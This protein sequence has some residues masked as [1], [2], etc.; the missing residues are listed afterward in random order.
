MARSR[1]LAAHADTATQSE[2]AAAPPIEI[3]LSH[4]YAGSAIIAAL[5]YPTN[6]R[7]REEM[8][9]TSAA[10]LLQRAQDGRIAAEVHGLL[11]EAVVD[12]A[13]EL[14]MTPGEVCANA[15]VQQQLEVI[16]KRL[17]VTQEHAAF[18]TAE[19]FGDLGG[20]DTVA[21]ARGRRA[22]EDQVQKALDGDPRDAG[23]V[24]LTWLK[25]ERLHKEKAPTLTNACSMLA[26]TPPDQGGIP[27]GVRELH[28]RYNEHCAVAPLYAAAVA[29]IEATLGRAILPSEFKPQLHHLLRDRAGRERMLRWAT[30][31]QNRALNFHPNHRPEYERILPPEKCIEHRFGVAAEEP[32]LLKLGPAAL[33]IAVRAHV[34]KERT[35][36]RRSKAPAT[37]R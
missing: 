19:H 6:I 15:E 7:A 5:V 22:I 36:G 16:W 17:S 21:E 32:Q 12:V 23:F 10:R 26:L 27:V 13:L 25:L 29:E 34:T 14:G 11:L 35:T 4:P 28:D 8:Q 1:R 33:K 30:A 24:L 31:I 3:N 20:L 2:V 18:V 9:A 37:K